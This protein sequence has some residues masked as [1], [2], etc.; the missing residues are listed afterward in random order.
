[1]CSSFVWH[2]AILKRSKWDIIINAHRFSC[3]VPNIPV[4][5][6]WNLNFLDRFWK[7]IQISYFIK[8]LSVRDDLFHADR[9][10]DEQTDSRRV[11]AKVTVAFSNFTNTPNN[12]AVCPHIMLTLSCPIWF[13]QQGAIL[14]TQYWLVFVKELQCVLCDLGIEPVQYV[15]EW[16]MLRSFWNYQL[17]IKMYD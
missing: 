5:F 12:Y 13:L 16:I 10:T 2:I 15:S 6:W 1:V 3:K 11:M 7:N 4:R 9:W 17:S 8:F 14:A